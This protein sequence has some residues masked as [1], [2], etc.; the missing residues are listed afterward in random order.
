MENQQP[1][2]STE[3]PSFADLRDETLR[4]SQPSRQQVG[5][6][7]HGVPKVLFK[8][9][10]EGLNNDQIT[11]S[12]SRPGMGH[13]RWLRGPINHLRRERRSNYLEYWEHRPTPVQILSSQAVLF[14]V[15]SQRTLFSVNGFLKGKNGGESLAARAN[16]ESKLRVL[17][18]TEAIAAEVSV[19]MSFIFQQSKTDRL[20]DYQ[21][22]SILPFTARRPARSRAGKHVIRHKW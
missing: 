16:F 6:T 8:G 15:P 3:D 12:S 9:S 13:Y 2:D 19:V 1:V 17:G 5:T 22:I 21:R 10:Y 11:G 14:F 4:L 20:L 18:K 7:L